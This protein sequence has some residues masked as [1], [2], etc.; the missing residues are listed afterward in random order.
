MLWFK[1]WLE[2]RWRFIAGLVL[3]AGAAVSVAM[4]Y[5]QARAMIP[6]ARNMPTD[7]V[8]GEQI[9]KAAEMIVTFR[10]YAQQQWNSQNIPQLGVLFAIMLGS[11]GVFSQTPAG[12]AMF[13][14]ALPVSRR[15]LMLTRAAM[16]LGELG[17]ILLVS[18]LA[19]TLAALAI[20]ENYGITDALMHALLAFI[21]CS[22]FFALALALSSVF[23]DVWRP[24]L[25]TIVIACAIGFTELML[26]DK[27]TVGIFHTIRGDDWYASSQLPWAGL[28][29]CF[30][31]SAGLIFAAVLHLERRDF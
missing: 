11:G 26:G 17:L 25:F 27:L 29:L 2:T 4:I 30:A 7:G 3:L 18:A 15:R 10:G 14:L 13:T 22:V 24:L 1:S 9:R 20:G 16:G 21:G 12:G 5:P 8:I 19:L 28:G 6:M 23:A 31:L